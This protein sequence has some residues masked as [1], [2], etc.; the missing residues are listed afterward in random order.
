MYP[1][2]VF[3]TSLICVFE[4]TVVSVHI[5]G[6]LAANHHQELPMLDVQVISSEGEDVICISGIGSS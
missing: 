6:Q 3:S 2:C 1:S 4:S 5:S